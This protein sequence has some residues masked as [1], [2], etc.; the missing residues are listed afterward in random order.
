MS[1]Y[2]N[3]K[4]N[5]TK[6]NDDNNSGVTTMMSYSNFKK[7]IFELSL[8][9]NKYHAYAKNP[10]YEMNLLSSDYFEMGFR[11]FG[12]IENKPLFLFLII[13]SEISKFFETFA[14]V[15]ENIYLIIIMPVLSIIV[16][17]IVR[18]HMIQIDFDITNKWK[19]ITFEYFNNLSYQTRKKCDMNDFNSQINRTSWALTH[20]VCNGLINMVSLGFVFVSCL[21]T[22]YYESQLYF[23]ILFSGLFYVYHTKKIKYKQE[24]LSKLREIKKEA[25]K[26]LQP[27]IHWNLHLF[28]NRKKTYD[29]IMEIEDPVL[30]ANKKFI[31]EWETI[32][33]EI[34]SFTELFVSISLY[35]V[36]NDIKTIFKNKIIFNQLTNSITTINH[37][38]S[39]FLND[40]KEFDRFIDWIKSSESDPI[41][42]QHM[43][44]FPLEINSYIILNSTEKTKFK[45]KICNSKKIILEAPSLTIQHNDK[46]LLRGESGIG[47]TVLVNSLQGLI[48]GANF[49]G[50][51]VEMESMM[52]S[53]IEYGQIYTKL[54][55]K[56]F[57]SRWEYM[58]QQTRETI[59]AC[60]LSLRQMLEDESDNEKIQKLVEITLLQNKFN[61]SNYDEPME[62]LSGGERMRLSILYTL[63]DMENGHKQILILDEPE[64][65]LDEDIRVKI[66]DNIIKFISKPILIIYHGSKL[67]LLQLSFT[68]VWEFTKVNDCKTQESKTFVSEIQW[69]KFRIGLVK[70]IKDIIL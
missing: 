18:K 53:D 6:K 9:L 44:V 45:N 31:M 21:I 68:K 24:N 25:E 8:K 56:N 29:K 40:I 50:I 16:N 41:E 27:L 20:I 59:P 32:S 67:D 61:Y 12:M 10:G 34:R 35:F 39:M 3:S 43:I 65:G 26:K 57:E 30:I 42:T 17:Y 48:P 51:S 2:F 49:K 64:Q 60:G 15:S 38:A 28:Q 33:S 54:N 19:K 4:Q 52:D 1:F 36:S 5:N 46:I 69:K 13:L 23:I 62:G 7:Y 14:I 37:M 63:W 22:F 66:I 47:K 70:E 58:N 11:G 55:L